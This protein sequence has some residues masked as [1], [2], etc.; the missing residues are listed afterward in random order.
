[1][2]NA[3]KQAVFAKTDSGG[4]TFAYARVF[5]AFGAAQLTNAWQP[6]G[7]G[8]VGKGLL[9]GVIT[10]GSDTAYNFLQEF[11]PFTRPRSLRHRR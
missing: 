7:N 2:I 6:K 11:V 3:L 1:M 5:S 10:L 4:D 9:R 8:S